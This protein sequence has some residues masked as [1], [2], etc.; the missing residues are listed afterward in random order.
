MAK[1]QPSPHQKNKG[2]FETVFSC[3]AANH[4]LNKRENKF[5]TRFKNDMV[6]AYDGENSEHEYNLA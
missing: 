1:K 5:Y 2:V 3:C 4:D 6:G